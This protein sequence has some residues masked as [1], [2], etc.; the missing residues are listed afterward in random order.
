[1]VWNIR[2]FLIFWSLLFSGPELNHGRGP[3]KGQKLWR[4][5]VRKML[6]T[7]QSTFNI[8][9]WKG[10]YK[11]QFDRWLVRTALP[12][13]AAIQH[14]GTLLLWR[15]IRVQS[16][17]KAT[18]PKKSLHPPNPSTSPRQFKKNRGI[19]YF[20]IWKQNIKKNSHRKKHKEKKSI[21]CYLNSVTFSFQDGFLYFETSTCSDV[22]F[23]VKN[24]F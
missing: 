19:F 15:S 23:I 1:M 16:F 10:P 13:S 9:F 4:V 20:Q 18:V 3:Q 5:P 11:D 12:T 6:P 2:I 7:V 8:K 14:H 22:C 21:N 17:E 24:F